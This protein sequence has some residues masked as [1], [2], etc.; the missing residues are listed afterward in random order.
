MGIERKREDRNTADS[1][2]HH[3]KQFSY[4]SDL[5]IVNLR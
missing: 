2:L 1:I 4:L 5:I 3:K